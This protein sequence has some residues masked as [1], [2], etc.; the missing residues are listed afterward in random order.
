MLVLLFSTNQSF[1]R[2]LNILHIDSGILD[3]RLL[4]DRS[5]EYK[6]INFPIEYGI[7]DVRQLEDRSRT[8]NFDNKPIDDGI[9]NIRLLLF[10]FK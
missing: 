2:K 10:R 3:V 1:R 7:L 8:S 4:K 6:F 5:K 9:L